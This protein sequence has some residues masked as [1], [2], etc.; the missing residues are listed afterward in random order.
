MNSF[1]K[2]L[3]PFKAFESSHAQESSFQDIIDEEEAAAEVEELPDDRSRG[4][5]ESDFDADY[6]IRQSLKRKKCDMFVVSED[7]L[8]IGGTQSLFQKFV[9]SGRIWVQYMYID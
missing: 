9:K 2:N 4:Q 7:E 3:K 1:H 5:S 6:E 8:K